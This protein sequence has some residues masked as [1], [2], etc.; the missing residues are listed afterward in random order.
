[1]RAS[2]AYALIGL[3]LACHSGAD[4]GWSARLHGAADQALADLGHALEPLEGRLADLDRQRLRAAMGVEAFEAEYAAGRTLDLASG[5]GCARAPGR[6]RRAGARGSR[7]SAGDAGA[8]RGATPGALAGVL[9][10]AVSGEAA[11]VLTPRELDVLK[12]V[13]QGLSNQDIAARLVLSEHTVHR[14]LANILRKLH[15]SS[16]AAAAAW[17]VRTGL[18]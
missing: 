11:S 3:A 7:G 5:A 8:A 13:A 4:P 14:H 9:D 2:T 6:S 18:A 15:L 10:A 17:G 16:R 12:L 1:M